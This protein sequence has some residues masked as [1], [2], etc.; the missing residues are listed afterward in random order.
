MS[1]S[2]VDRYVTLRNLRFH[3]RDWGGSGQP[4]VLLHGLASNSHIWDLVAP[5]LAER[6]SVVALDQRSHGETEGADE[7]YDFETIVGDLDAFLDACAIEHPIIVGHSWGGNVAIH[8]GAAS[9]GKV[10]ALVC[11]DGGFIGLR[12]GSNP[13]WQEVERNLAPPDLTH[14]TIGQLISRAREMRWAQMWRPEV[15]AVLRSSF[16]ELPDG[17]I[18]PRLS[19]ERHMQ[20]VRALWE[21]TPDDL[22]SRVTVPVLLLPARHPNQPQRSAPFNVPKEERVA[23]AEAMLRN[24]RSVWLEDSIHDVPLQRP[25]LVSATITAAHEDGFLSR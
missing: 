12:D 22:Y 8:A 17:T 24:A 3:Y 15:E 13:T 23:R 16:Y 4:V 7:G 11:I 20:I 6:F 1:G 10:R 2:V 5:L 14:M 18:R 9:K 25:E 21:Q 19:R